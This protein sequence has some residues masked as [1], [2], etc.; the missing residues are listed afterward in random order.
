[1]SSTPIQLKN[2]HVINSPLPDAS[3][4]AA[5]YYT[6]LQQYDTLQEGQNGK[7]AIAVRNISGVGMDSLLVK[8]SI[9]D[10]NQV[11]HDVVYPI[12]D[13]LRP[14]AILIDTISFSTKGLVGLNFFTIEVNHYSNGTNIYHQPELTYINN[15]LQIPFYVIEEN[16]NPILDVTF[17][18][19]RIMNDEIISPKSTV[20]IT[21]KDENPYLIMDN[22]S[23]TS[24]FG[25]YLTYPSGIQKRIPFLDENGNTIM[26]WT[27]ANSQNKKF[28]ITY[29]GDFNENGTYTLSVQGSDKTGNL[30]GDLEYKVSFKIDHESKI[31]QVLN[32]PNPFSSNTRFVFTLTGSEIP[33]IFRIKIFT[34]TGKLIKEIDES[35]IG[36]INIGNNITTYAWDGKDEYGDQ[37]ANGVYLYTVESKVNGKSIPTMQTS[38]D[39]YFKKG[40]GKMYLI[41]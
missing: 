7:F 17:D 16:I 25:I 39:G 3:I 19:R 11:I 10:Q 23:D 35:D 20:L 18:G 38:T 27:P 9:I 34:V 5:T 4:D 41:R 21:L 1:V 28:K 6:G 33:E 40:I 13:S 14:G 2:W 30:S 31:T 37:L 36:P 32:Y 24:R 29:L 26:E 15:L 22:D 8:Y 12:Q